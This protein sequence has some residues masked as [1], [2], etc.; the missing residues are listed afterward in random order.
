MGLTDV[1]RP[2][3]VDQT[4][5]TGTGQGRLTDEEVALLT[6]IVDSINDRFG[7]EVT[8]DDRVFYQAVDERMSAGPELQQQAAVNDE[9]TFQYAFNDAFMEA[10]ID[11]MEHNTDL[12][13]RL[14][15]D[16]SYANIVKT[17]MLR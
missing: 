5:F 6:E 9:Q 3:I 15:D 2:T 7:A 11:A 8:D 4:G 1:T 14:L 12:G 10:V 17:W 13:K 16:P